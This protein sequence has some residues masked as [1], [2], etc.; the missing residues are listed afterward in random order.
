MKEIKYRGKRPK[1]EIIKIGLFGM[2]LCVPKDWTEIEI[3]ESIENTH[4][5]G[6]TGGWRIVKDGSGLLG[7][8]PA[9]VQC[10]EKSDFV[11]V[12]VEC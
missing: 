12:L 4:A 2:Q 10:A 7:D 5:C 6:T 11:H 1:A 3:I 8:D 9:R